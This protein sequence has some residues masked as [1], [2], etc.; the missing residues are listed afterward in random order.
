MLTFIVGV[1]LVGLLLLLV[2]LS[3]ILDEVPH[4]HDS[5]ER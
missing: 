2:L 5:D 4:V 3:L 1:I